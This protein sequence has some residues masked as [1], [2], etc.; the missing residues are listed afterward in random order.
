MDGFQQL[1][2]PEHLEQVNWE[3]G[4]NST[5]PLCGPNSPQTLDTAADIIW[6][7]QEEEAVASDFGDLLG[8]GGPRPLRP[9][10]LPIS[11]VSWN[12]SGSQ[13]N[14]RGEEERLEKVKTSHSRQDSPAAATNYT[15][16]F[17]PGDSDGGGS[18]VWCLLFL[19]LPSRQTR[20]NFNLS[21]DVTCGICMKTVYEK[22][23]AGD[24]RFGILPELQCHL[25]KK[26]KLPGRSYKGLPKVQ[27]QV[28]VLHPQQV[29]GGRTTKGNPYP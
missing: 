2:S 14:E 26:T 6:T 24:R 1:P 4:A 12:G 22:T 13:Q 21:K 17:L 10:A 19:P 16:A 28:G 7:A 5:L 25:E 29:L 20:T 3:T 8:V 9:T 23:S 15:G 18:R 11:R 27:S